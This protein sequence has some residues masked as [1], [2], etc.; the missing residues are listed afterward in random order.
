MAFD[1]ASIIFYIIVFLALYSQ[2]FF[3]YYFFSKRKTLKKET[4]YVAK[5]EDL[6]GVTFVIACWNESETIKETM[7]S[8]QSL[9]YPKE[10]VHVVL[11]DDGSSDDTLFILNSYKDSQNIQILSKENGGKHSALNYALPHVSTELM[12]SIDADTFIEPDALLK[13]SSYFVRD[14]E[15]A[16]VGGAVLINKPR[17]FAQKAQSIEYQ[18]FAYTKKVLGLMN[19]VMVAPGAFS[20]YKTKTLI[21][22]GGYK[23]A[24][25]LEDL[26]LTYR[27]QVG[28]Y[29]VD[30]CHNAIVYTK[31]PDT[32]KSLFRQR[33]R[34]GY[35]FLNN[36]IDYR[37]TI[38]N[39]KLGN[40]GLF[41]VPMSV[42]SY[43]LVL[44]VFFISWYKL[45]V[46]LIEQ[47]TIM[48]LT[49][50][51][52]LF[53]NLLSFDWFFVNTQAIAV[54]TLVMY[55]TIFLSIYL[56]RK[57]SSIK[58]GSYVNILLFFAL[59]SFVVPFWVIKSVYNT[60]LASTPS[61]R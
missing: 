35:G 4:S 56:G 21:E 46:V 37:K 13:I 33:M 2:I 43:F 60:A 18:M 50:S 42:F 41:T 51:F 52:G 12:C 19:G 20:L 27:F 31:G 39:R 59:Y 23:K 25:N 16:V 28:G 30:Q 44:T 14:P 54:L 53:S 49:G 26:E 48:K 6:P 45:F 57:V 3:L 40:F 58:N 32:I 1:W 8:V 34:W 15:L 22:I 38:F 9:I 5:D 24:H 36:T 11:V 17:T 61:W 47:I 10:K 29:K 7:K 55:A